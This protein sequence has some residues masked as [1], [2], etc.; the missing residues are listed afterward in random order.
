M[1]IPEIKTKTIFCRTTISKGARLG[2]SSIQ[3]EH[4]YKGVYERAGFD[5]NTESERKSSPTDTKSF[6]STRSNPKKSSNGIQS[7]T[8]SKSVSP[9]SIKQQSFKSNSAEQLNSKVNHNHAN[10]QIKPFAS[11]SSNPYNAPTSAKSATFGNIKSMPYPMSPPLTS[12]RSFSESQL[13]MSNT[14]APYQ[15]SFSESKAV[16]P[17]KNQQLPNPTPIEPFKPSISHQKNYKN[18][19]LNLDDG[20][21]TENYEHEGTQKIYD[22]DSENE[23]I[24]TISPKE[25]SFDET[26]NT[27]I[28]KSDPIKQNIPQI[29][30]RIPHNNNNNNE[31]Y[32]GNNS[33]VNPNYN[34][35]QQPQHHIAQTQIPQQQP[36]QMGPAQIPQQQQQHQHYGF[37]RINT[38]QHIPQQQPKQWNQ[39]SQGSNNYQERERQ[40]EIPQFKIDAPEANFSMPESNSTYRLSNALDEF[41][42]DIQAHKNYVPRSPSIP[43]TPPELPASSPTELGLTRFEKLVSNPKYGTDNET[44]QLPYPVNELSIAPSPREAR[45]SQLSMVSSIISKESNYSDDDD[46]VEKELKRQLDMLKQNGGSDLF[47]K[48]ESSITESFDH[49]EV[50][51]EANIPQ[52]QI[53]NMDDIP[54]TDEAEEEEV[55][56]EGTRNQEA[57]NTQINEA[58]RGSDS[59]SNS[60]DL[61]DM[62]ST[63]SYDSVKPLSVRHSAN[64]SFN[65]IELPPSPAKF[66]K[67]VKFTDV[68]SFV[69]PVRGNFQN[70]SESPLEASFPQSPTPVKSV[71]TVKIEEDVKPLSPKNHEIEKELKGLNFEIQQA[72]ESPSQ[73]MINDNSEL[74]S[75]DAI[76]SPINDA[77]VNEELEQESREEGR[78]VVVAP[79]T[80]PC[81]SCRNPI[82]SNAK[83]SQKA[84]YSKTGELSGQWHRSC[85]QCAYDDCGIVFSKNVQCYALHNQPY[86]FSHYH[87]LNNT[88]CEGCGIG[89]EGDCIENELEQKWHLNCLTCHKCNDMINNDYFLING[90][91]FCESDAHILISNS[92]QAGLSST[93]K[94]E[95][96]RTRLLF[97]D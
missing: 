49:N 64:V 82:L 13:P 60:V 48:E 1:S 54:E 68:D 97:L 27:S 6:H 44:Q 39:P 30:S 88:T 85:F 83:G 58:K 8:D 87:Q 69:S 59:S 5:V 31:S 93:D 96:R 25:N 56:E 55:D 9:T 78:H 94:I 61:D 72:T 29:Q 40:P 70:I 10:N 28:D 46:A 95:K 22:S 71:P 36:Y 53:N 52:I 89:I 37:P 62:S 84:I 76:K 7:P 18:L 4:R 32:N 57:V 35:Y 11:A 63:A 21:Q 47:E 38:N 12:T 92:H 24:N 67:E 73:F 19:R 14:S 34:P 16:S 42:R 86:C 50:D 75:K 80:G 45:L 74:V 23:M 41:K 2:V 17:T 77:N 79:G 3:V 26:R 66:R 90:K 15:R 43:N 51:Q 65:T 91:I 33:G 20:P 81:R